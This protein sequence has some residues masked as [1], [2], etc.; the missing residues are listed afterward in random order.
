MQ[1]KHHLT[2]F[3]IFNIACVL[4]ASAQTITT[5]GGNT[6][7]G[8]VNNVAID[9]AGNL[10]AADFNVA[11]V[12]KITPQ[13]GTTVFAGT[14][15]KAGY[16]GDGGPAT[17]A[18][19]SEPLGTAIGPDGSLY[20]ADYG[21]ARIR[22]V[23]LSGV[24]TTYA[25]TSTAGFLGDGGPATSARL[26]GP[27]TITFDSKG[28][29]Y[30]VDYLNRRIRKVGTD[31]VITT[32]AGSGNFTV[33]GDGGL[34]T[35][36]DMVPG[37]VAVGPDGSI[38]FSDDGYT[39]QGSHR[40]RK[41]APNG[42][43]STVAGDKTSGFTGDGGAATS[44]ELRSVDGVAIDSVGN[45]FIAESDGARIRKVAP[46]GIITTYAGTGVGG[47]AG[48]G[49]PALAAQF[50]LPTGLLEDSQDNL[51]V[52]DTNNRKIRKITPVPTP[53]IPATSAVTP[54][55]LGRSNFGSNMFVEIYGTNLAATSRQWASS[56]FNGASAPTKLDGV[57]VT[58]NGKPA[59]I[60][61][62]SPG[63]VNI[64]TPD[65]TALGPVDIQVTNSYGVVSNV[66]T[67]TRVRVS[68][69]LHTVPL[70]NV[71]GKQYVAAHTPDFSTFIGQPGMIAGVPFAAAKPGD[72][73]IIFALGCGPTNP[74]VPAGTIAQ[75]T[76]PLASNY[77]V[78]IGG[79]AA[80]VQFAGMT[81][82][83][84][85]L[86]Q[87]NVVIPNLSPGDQ[88]IELQVDGVSNA[89]N[90]YITVGQ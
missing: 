59:F 63:Q 26:N 10:Y 33:S 44:A 89:Q 17:S 87:F 3:A 60:N 66:G 28:A 22:K 47:S 54:S 1:H 85:G 83:N 4:T 80:Q 73:V 58:V 76:S 46:N 12:Y 34:A 29:L 79:V 11:V 75:Q 78:L 65:D 37:F 77:M 25:G 18:T 14:S 67:A 88:T 49:G 69:T 20:I 82:G 53:T 71:G 9:S 23:S 16:S 68:P 86:Y 13:G 21:N 30:I 31:G 36:T 35:A 39:A 70:F 40:L 61:Y 56:D 90:L 52:V 84:V 24:I 42:L 48:D 62:V 81:A 64:N 38:Y 41:V 51:Y 57:S 43:V 6:S 5:V 72:V 32:V 2:Y 7:W 50:N 8:R 19:L 74:A 27:F 45:I 15:N 55:F